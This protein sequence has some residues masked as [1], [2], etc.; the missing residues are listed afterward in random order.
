[1]FWRGIQIWNQ[2]IM[3]RGRKFLWRQYEK[4]VLTKLSKLQ[5]HNKYTSLWRH[6]NCRNLTKFSKFCFMLLIFKCKIEKCA[7]L[8][9]VIS[10][11]FAPSSELSE[12]TPSTF[13][14]LNFPIWH[15][16]FRKKFEI[17][18]AIF[19]KKARRGNSLGTQENRST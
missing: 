18:I 8:D 13:S 6:T 5:R 16:E 9:F 11:I 19:V 2:F 1:M 4:G 17:K 14:F 15:L 12:W 10:L 3:K 7:L